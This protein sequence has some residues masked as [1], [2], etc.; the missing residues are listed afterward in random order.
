MPERP[1]TSRCEVRR[2]GPQNTGLFI[3][4]RFATAHFFRQR[5]ERFSTRA[6]EIRLPW[7]PQ[8]P[9]T[10]GHAGKAAGRLFRDK[11]KAG[12]VGAQ[13]ARGDAV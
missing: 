3:P 1:L 9:C 4:R 6:A 12:I 13:G 7:S 5:P 11:R 8:T 2:R 10:I